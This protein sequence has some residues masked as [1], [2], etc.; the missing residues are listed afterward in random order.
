MMVML[1]SRLLHISAK[2]R[3]HAIADNCFILYPR[4][5]RSW[6]F[7]GSWTLVFFVDFVKCV[8]RQRST[9]VWS[10]AGSVE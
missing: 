2:I 7:S 9:V 8:G 5:F 6:A 3:S 10:S 1:R 4:E